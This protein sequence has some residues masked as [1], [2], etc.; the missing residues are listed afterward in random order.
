MILLASFANRGRLTRAGLLVALLAAS[1]SLMLAAEIY[2]TSSGE[3]AFDAKL[4]ESLRSFGHAVTIGVPY[5]HLDGT[6][7]LTGNSAIYL[8]TN[9]NW[10][11]G[12]LSVAGQTALV[13]FVNRGGGL[14][15]TEWL[16]WAMSGGQSSTLD[17]IIPVNPTSNYDEAGTVT[18]SQDVADSEIN[19]GLAS[20]V[21]VPLE[22]IEGTRT[23]VAS[24]RAG[25]TSFYKMDGGYIGLAGWNVGSG[26]VLT[27]ATTN[28]QAQLNDV[29]FR[30]L[31]SNAMSWVQPGA[32][33][34][35]EAGVVNAASLLAG[36]PVAPG[37]L[38]S[39]FGSNLASSRA[40]AESVP[41]PRSLGGVRV[42]FNNI[43]APLYFVSSQQI[44][45]QLPWA[46]LSTGSTSGTVSMVVRRGENVS[47]AVP[48]Q[49]G[50]VSPGI[51]SIGYGVGQ[52]IASNE[53]G[54]LAAP[55]GSIPG[56]LSQPARIGS[57]I[58]VLG[59]GLGVVDPPGGDGQAS[60]DTQ[61]RTLVTP[62][63]LIGGVE[64]QV[65]FSGLDAQSPGVYRLTVVV[66]SVTPGDQVPIQIRLGGITSSDRI[67]ISLRN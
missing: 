47:Q 7:N 16:L 55:V 57:T 33:V 51:F 5:Y 18:F 15:T 60:L 42:T 54:S 67:T 46:V 53:N 41:V 24:T 20:A 39:V 25:A 66:P 21:R 37:S 35:S 59:T 26:R 1:N 48:V 40:I 61:R 34:V 29:N 49:V 2:V 8:Q 27:F 4:Q 43:D 58:A 65:L 36:L 30:Q 64:S 13:N 32:P 38:V 52:A 9:Y 63:V 44:N 11:A 12:Q 10:S 62:S 3:P 22:S 6:Q 19:K 23:L 14:V 56:I 50:P 28:G 17:P 45:A 31:L